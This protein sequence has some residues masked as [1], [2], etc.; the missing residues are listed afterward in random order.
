MNPAID[1]ARIGYRMIG[2]SIS[3]RLSMIRSSIID[4]RCIAFSSQRLPARNRRGSET[5]R[6]IRK[7]PCV[8]CLSCL[9]GSY[10]VRGSGSRPRVAPGS[11][12]PGSCWSRRAYPRR[13][14]RTSSVCSTSFVG[15]RAVS[16]HRV[17]RDEVADLPW[18]PG[19]RDVEHPEAG[20]E[21]GQ[22]HQRALFL[23]VGMVL[24]LIDVV[25]AEAGALLSRSPRTARPAAAPAAA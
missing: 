25:R 6:A 1:E 11:R 5:Q 8:L 24:E 15:H 4:H 9:C 13:S 16:L 2:D 22:V 14:T 21:V 23:H 7:A 17:G 19:V 10:S 3:D 20:V 12:A 18:Q